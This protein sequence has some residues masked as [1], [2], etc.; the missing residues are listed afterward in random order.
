[1]MYSNY[2]HTLLR[3]LV[4]FCCINILNVNATKRSFILGINEYDNLPSYSQLQR[5]INDARAISGIFNDPDKLG[6]EGELY[7]NLKRSEF[8]NAWQNFLNEVETGDT[9]AIFIAGHGVELEG[10]NYILPSDIPHVAHGGR[11]NQLTGPRYCYQF[12]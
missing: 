3:L 7:V 2:F 10:D 1:M 11:Q 5:P 8:N 12:E 4:I 6:Y 9:V